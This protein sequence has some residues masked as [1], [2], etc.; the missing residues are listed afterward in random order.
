PGRLRQIVMN[1]VDNG[2]K[3]TE[4][5][6]VD[7][8]IKTE[9]KEGNDTVLLH[10]S[11]RD[12]GIG[13]PCK[14]HKMIFD[15]FTQADGSTTRKYGGTGLG[16]SIS[17]QLVRMMG[18]DI[19]V[20]DAPDHGAVFHF[21][22]RLKLLMTPLSKQE[23]TSFQ[24]I[25]SLSILIADDDYINQTLAALLIENMGWEVTA[26]GNGK[27]VLTAL[28][29]GRFDLV[30]MDVQM[31]EMNGFE[32]AEKLQISGKPPC[33]IFMTAYD[34]FAIKAFEINALDYVLKP[35]VQGRLQKSIDRFIS[36]GKS[37]KDSDFKSIS[38]LMEELQKK[39]SSPKYLTIPQGEC[40]RPILIDNIV[41]V[42][43]N[44]RDVRIITTEGEFQ[45]TRS[46]TSMDELLGDENFF[47]CHR[48][49]IINLNHIK[50]I[51]IWFNNTYQLEMEGIMEKI[52]V[53]R[54]YISRFREIMAIS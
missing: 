19:W 3:F 37:E 16:L 30:L 29:T 9:K 24:D 12:T 50:K 33:I 17:Y 18:G 41:A 27:D 28:E 35:F 14:K 20:E 44:S 54:S 2:I 49:Y 15:A 48:S 7:I 6:E 51:D 32:V 43:A 22:S 34:K 53:S 46:I 39:E 13:I 31:P 4:K 26:V 8:Q 40:Y 11:I 1:M 47:R 38:R 52:P 36:R 23:Q 25:S 10:F 21:T 5:G 45:H 42:A